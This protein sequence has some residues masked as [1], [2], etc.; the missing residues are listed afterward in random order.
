[1]FNFWKNYKN[2][3]ANMAQ[4]FIVKSVQNYTTINKKENNEID[5]A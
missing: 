4:Y 2:I 1:M 3:F 5:I